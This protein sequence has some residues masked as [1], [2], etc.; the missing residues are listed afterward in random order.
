MSSQRDGTGADAAPQDQQADLPALADREGILEDLERV[1]CEAWESFDTPRTA[2]P[3]L[4]EMLIGCLES[5]L[6]QKAGDPDAILADA[7]RVLDASISPSRP[8][9]LGYIDSTGLEI[10][11]LASA[12]R[13]T[14]DANLAVAAGGADLVEEQTLRWVSDFV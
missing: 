10:G 12:L 7:A 14:Y 3:Q 2:E 5:P 8:L 13:A 1:I 11:V 9:Y 4:D 6:P